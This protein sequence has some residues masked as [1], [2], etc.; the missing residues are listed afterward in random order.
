MN[1]KTCLIPHPIPYQGSKRWIAPTVARCL[2][3]DTQVLIE[4]FAGSAAVSLA[5]AYWRRAKK[6]VLGDVNAPLIALWAEIIE[7]PQELSRAYALLWRE[8][9]GREREYYN[10]VRAEFNKSHRP[11]LLLYLLARCVK[12]A[13]RY[14]SDGEFNNSPDNRRR[15]ARPATM[16]ERI[17]GASQLLRAKTGLQVGDYGELLERARPQDVVYMD[18]PYQGVCKKRDARYLGPVRFE[19]LVGRLEG[20][21]RRG[22]SY[23]VSYDGRTGE[24]RHG[25]TLPSE[26]GLAHFE[27]EAGCSTQA[28]LLG[29]REKTYESLYLSE[30]LLRRIDVLPFPLKSGRWA[31]QML[32]GV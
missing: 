17:C 1:R 23:I 21:N 28:T 25:R 24:R 32:I 27:V 2:P 15:G 4:P 11:D 12:A 5:A 20:L 26:L 18:P 31:Q 7:R 16:K 8:Q 3:T 6:F 19:D 13:V 14:N 30:A 22:I 9:E 10:Q 29:R